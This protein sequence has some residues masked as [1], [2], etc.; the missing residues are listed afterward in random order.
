MKKVGYTSSLVSVRSMKFV[1]NKSSVRK[2]P[3]VQEKKI[4]DDILMK[5][6]TP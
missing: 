4:C 2:I 3:E 5:T 6:K 1:A